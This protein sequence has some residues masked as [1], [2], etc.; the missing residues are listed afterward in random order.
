MSSCEAHTSR[1]DDE[2]EAFSDASEQF[3][4]NGETWRSE[5]CAFSRSVSLSGSLPHSHPFVP[6]QVIYKYMNIS[7]IPCTGECG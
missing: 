6:T 3:S 1:E 2:E 5:C 4:D 7:R